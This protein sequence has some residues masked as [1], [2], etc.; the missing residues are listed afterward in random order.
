MPF[1]SASAASDEAEAPQP[2]LA[3]GDAAHEPSHHL[4]ARA[5]QD[6]SHRGVE[7]AVVATDHGGGL[8]RVGRAT[9]EAQERELVDGA[10]LVR[11]ASHR[12]GESGGDRAG[13][14]RV[15]ERL[16]GPE[17]RGERHRGEELGQTERARRRTRVRA[18]HDSER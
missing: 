15:A 6:R 16:T 10:D 4:P 14:Q 9:Q 11:A 17:V 7:R 18:D 1:G 5:H 8:R 3:G 13:A 2:G 12:L